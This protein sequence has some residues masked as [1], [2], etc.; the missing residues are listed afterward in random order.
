[1]KQPHTIIY[2]TGLG[3]KP[4]SKNVSLQR[5]TIKAWR[6]FGVD[7]TLFQMGWADKQQSFSEKL[8]HLLDLVDELYGHGHR[9]SLV[10]VSAGASVVIAAFAARKQVVSGVVCICGK[11]S[12]PETVSPRY[13]TQNP[14]FQDAMNGLH[15]TLSSLGPK[16]RKSILSIRPLYDQT[17]MVRDTKI[18]R[19][20]QK[21][22]PSFWH[23]PSIAL[24]ITLFSPISILFLKRQAKIRI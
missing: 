17:V 11:L 8:K 3:D 22:I 24:A 1:M 9:V 4:G 6:I 7:T 14:A 16:E 19:V 13:Y 15:S 12:H 2:V 18:E 10:G 20:Q 23:T 5:M 21:T